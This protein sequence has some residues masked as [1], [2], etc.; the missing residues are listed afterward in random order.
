MHKHL[1][2]KK[3]LLTQETDAREFAKF[4]FDLRL[5][6]NEDGSDKFLIGEISSNFED[7]EGEPIF[8]WRYN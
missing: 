7:L 5:V 8:C 6:M 4:E 3:P 2:K 1:E